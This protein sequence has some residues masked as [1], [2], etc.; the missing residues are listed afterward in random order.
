MSA[1]LGILFAVVLL[2]GLALF[3]RRAATV[4]V[5]E[6][7][8]GRVVRARGRATGEM[9]RDMADALSGASDGKIELVLEDRG[10]AVRI[11]GLGANAEQRVRNVVGRFPSARLKTAPLVNVRRDE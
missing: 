9:M 1:W 6:V 3:A 2:V 10:V 8:R 7:V 4:L 5:V 11:V